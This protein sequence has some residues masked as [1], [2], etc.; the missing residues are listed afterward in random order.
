MTRARR[1][2]PSRA[3]AEGAAGALRGSVLFDFSGGRKPFTA[4]ESDVSRAR[5]SKLPPDKPEPIFGPHGWLDHTGLF[6]RLDVEVTPA[7]AT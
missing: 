5:K 2:P 7:P 1:A 4:T 6:D 3:S